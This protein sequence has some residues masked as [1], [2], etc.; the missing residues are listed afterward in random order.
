[1]T[2]QQRSDAVTEDELE[3]LDHAF[4]RSADDA[5]SRRRMR[6][7]FDK[8]IRAMKHPDQ[9]AAIAE[10]DATIAALRAQI[11]NMRRSMSEALNQGDGSYKP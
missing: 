5:V 6:K 4:R 8:A 7:V 1:M 10:R 2:D 3:L 11:V 9:S